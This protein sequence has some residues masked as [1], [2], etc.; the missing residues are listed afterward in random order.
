MSKTIAIGRLTL[1]EILETRSLRLAED[2][3]FFEEW[4]CIEPDLSTEDAHFLDRVQQDYFDQIR[5]GQLSEGL[6]K[7][8]VISPLLHLAGFYRYPYQVRLEES[9]QVE[10]LEG[11]ETWRGRI[12]ALVVQDALWIVVVE[13]KGAAFGI[14]QAIPQALGYMF[15]TPH[16][17]RPVY[18][19]VTNG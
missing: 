14:D 1:P 11:Q 16:P 9:V 13:S 6:I 3:Q 10:V 12:D 2:P 5:Q 7:L 17:Q 19:L 18:G 4:Q 8:V 15:A